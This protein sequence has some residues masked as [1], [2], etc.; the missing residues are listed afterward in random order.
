MSQDVIADVIRYAEAKRREW[1][2]ETR[3]TDSSFSPDIESAKEL[4]SPQELDELKE[5]DD[6]QYRSV[7]LDSSN[8][9]KPFKM[10][11]K[12]K[13]RHKFLQEKYKHIVGCWKP[14]KV[15]TYDFSKSLGSEKVEKPQECDS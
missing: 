11:R 2:D 13:D 15:L 10:T 14:Q 12:E 9:Y 7:A 4:L 8:R 6:L 3:K 5:Y 1:I